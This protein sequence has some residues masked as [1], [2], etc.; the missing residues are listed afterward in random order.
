MC[1]CLS[2]EAL[3]GLRVEE[4]HVGRLLP[5]ELISLFLRVGIRGQRKWVRVV[6]PQWRGVAKRVAG[7]G[8]G[9]VWWG[10]GGSLSSV[11]VVGG[12]RAHD[13][14]GQWAGSWRKVAT[15]HFGVVSS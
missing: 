6:L 10:G 8:G 3:V 7:G 1:V 9:Y 15:G 14:D 13:I 4:L 11:G 12:R 2:E 5:V